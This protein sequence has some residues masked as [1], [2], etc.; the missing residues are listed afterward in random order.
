MKI[1]D[2][3]THIIGKYGIANSNR[4]QIS[5]V[6]GGNLSKALNLE[7]IP[8]PAVFEKRWNDVAK[9][10]QI[11]SWLADDVQVPGFNVNTGDLKGYVPGVNMKYAHTKSFQECQISF[12]LDREH[13]PYKV[14]QRWGEYIFQHQDAG[15]ISGIRG[16]AAPDSFIKTAYYDDYT[17]DLIIDKLETADK[18]GTEVVSRYRLTNAFPYTVSAMTYANGPNQPVRF[19]ANF[20]FEF[21]REIEP[22]DSITDNLGYRGDLTTQQLTNMDNMRYGNSYQSQ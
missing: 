4:Y 15:D 10:S 21:M 22:D 7:P 3:R 14:M 1:R 17:A 6:P 12:I 5:F 20:N 9:D 11:F 2:I 18:S 16:R 13:T 8:D 19:M